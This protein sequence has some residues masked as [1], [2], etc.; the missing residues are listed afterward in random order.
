MSSCSRSTN[1]LSYLEGELNEHDR[2][3]FEKHLDSCPIC[4]H[5]LRLER[6]LQSG[7]VECTMPDAA[8]AELRSDVLSRILIGQ[9]PRF[10]F[11]QI[12]VTL[13]SGAVASLVLLQILHGSS[14]LETG[15]VLL[16]GFIDE[17]FTAVE[18]YSSLPLVIGVGIVLAGIASVVASLVPEE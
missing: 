4:R 17:I 12:A 15:I 6:T 2:V 14:L 10:P 8:P 5:E 9:R 3:L 11:W 18:K 16:M 1:V 7:L 13:L